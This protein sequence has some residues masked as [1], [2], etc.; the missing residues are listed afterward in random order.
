MSD[1]ITVYTS[2]IFVLIGSAN[3][4]CD[5][6]TQTPSK[7]K[8]LAVCIPTGTRRAKFCNNIMAMAMKCERASMDSGVSPSVILFLA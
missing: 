3:N 1:L 4:F 7:D 8:E 5:F 6:V 2:I